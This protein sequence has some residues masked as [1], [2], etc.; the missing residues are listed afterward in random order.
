ML[1]S[2]LILV[3]CF[4]QKR[5]EATDLSSHVY[6]AW[7]ASLAEQGRTPGVY[8]V[9]QWSN[10]AFDVGLE[11]LLVRVGS[12]A[13]QRIM[14]SVAVLIFFWGAVALSNV[15]AGKN[16][17]FTIPWVAVL[18]YGFVFHMGFFNY[19][20]SLGI[21]LC[22]LALAW[23]GGIQRFFLGTPLLF[24][25]WAAH[26]LPVIWAIGMLAYVMAAHRLR[27]LQT[28]G[29][30]GVG[31][32]LLIGIRE[33]LIWRFA[34]TWSWKQ[35]YFVTGINQPVFFNPAYTPIFGLFL[36]VS[37]V[38]FRTLIKQ[39]GISAVIRSIPLQVFLLNAAAVFV[40][41]SVIESPRYAIP[42]SFITDRLSLAAGVMACALLAAAPIKLPQK[43]ILTFAGLIFF[44]LVFADTWKLN[45]VED[46]VDHLVAQ[47]PSGA[48]VLN[49]FPTRNRH[50][51]P[52]LHALDRACIGHCLSYGNYEPMSR[53]FRVRAVPGNAFVIADFKDEHA[54]DTGK[55][56]VQP[57]DLP[58]YLIYLCGD[59][60]DHVCLKT[61]QAG[62]NVAQ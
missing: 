38:S 61:M 24:F 14:V 4:W 28:M 19:Y 37:V 43:L 8:V 48:R 39:H 20:L 50:I 53:Q 60:R 34:G 12:S 47:L 51:S 25:A 30:L 6:N 52:A 26:P 18:T 33:I 1:V 15:V 59:M 3:P 32:V 13:A 27:G 5:I 22:Y 35:V 55:Y 62:E 57:R 54:V 49:Y 56:V 31:I 10:V 7:L 42:F 58:V 40:L 16:W 45:R 29:L 23:K 2:L 17:W 41:P 21:C 11:G 9:R 46:S 36:L 44:G